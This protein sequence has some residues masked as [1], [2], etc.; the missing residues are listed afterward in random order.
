MTEDIK[1]CFLKN[2]SKRSV[3]EVNLRSVCVTEVKFRS[4]VSLRSRDGRSPDLRGGVR[5]ISAQHHH[6]YG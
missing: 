1:C 5:L 4:E 3:L 6:G 2:V